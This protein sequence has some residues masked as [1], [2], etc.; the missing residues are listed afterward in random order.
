MFG[1]IGCIN[2]YS[3]ESEPNRFLSDEREP[4]ILLQECDH[5]KNK[6]NSFTNNHDYSHGNKIYDKLFQ[7]VKRKH[8]DLSISA[9][10]LVIYYNLCEQYD[11]CCCVCTHNCDDPH[12]TS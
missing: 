3:G 10:N 7:I 9:C 4:N 2:K 8:P 11:C 1:N 12:H 6:N 5:C